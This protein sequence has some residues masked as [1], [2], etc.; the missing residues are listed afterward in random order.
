MHVTVFVYMFVTEL[1]N[2]C[3]RISICL[4]PTLYMVVTELVY[5]W[6]GVNLSLSLYKFISDMVYDCQRLCIVL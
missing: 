6:L 4:L 2:V 5:V 1:A 3:L